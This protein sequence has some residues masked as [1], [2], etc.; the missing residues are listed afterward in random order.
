MIIHLR[1]SDF[2][3]NI[4]SRNEVHSRILIVNDTFRSDSKRKTLL[5][6]TERPETCEHAFPEK[7]ETSRSHVR[8]KNISGTTATLLSLR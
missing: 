4:E 6:H 2:D 8:D 1:Y 3:V 7:R 5:V